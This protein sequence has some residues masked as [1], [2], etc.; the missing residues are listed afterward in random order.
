MFQIFKKKER[1]FTEEERYINRK[2]VVTANNNLSDRN[3][4]GRNG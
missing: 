3:F 2:K 1:C 4:F